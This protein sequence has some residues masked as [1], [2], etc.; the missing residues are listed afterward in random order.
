[1]FVT[2]LV[3]Y[4][5]LRNVKESPH[6]TT[7]TRTINRIDVI[8]IFSGIRVAAVNELDYPALTHGFSLAFVKP[9]TLTPGATVNNHPAALYFFHLF[10]TFRALHICLPH[11]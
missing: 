10:I 7:A 3:L 11:R 6:Q 9:Q 5:G 2:F 4:L 8:L 1:M